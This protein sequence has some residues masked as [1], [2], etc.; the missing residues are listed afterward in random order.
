[1]IG[2]RSAGIRDFLLAALSGL[3]LALPYVDRELFLLGWI[4]F[5]PLLWTLHDKRPAQAYRLGLVCGLVLYGVGAWWIVGFLQRLW[6]PGLPLTVL[7]SVLFWLYS[8]QLIALLMLAFQW[9]R[10]RTGW[11]A[12]LLFPPLVVLFFG[13]FPMLFQAQLGESQS[14]FLVALQGTSVV[15]VSGL[16]AMMALVSVLILRWLTGPRAP[17]HDPV[18]VIA[19]LLPMVWLVWGAVSLGH[20]DER[21]AESPTERVGVVQTNTGLNSA[22]QAP[23]YTASYPRAMALS[24][25]LARAGADLV[26]WPEARDNR[27]FQEPRVAAALR[28]ETARLSTAILLQGMEYVDGA[29]GRAEHNSTVLIDSG[30]REQGR[31]RKI[32][33]VAFGEYLPLLERF[34][35]ARRW[36]R[37]QLGEFFTQVAPGNGPER[38]RADAITVIPLI[39]YEALFPVLV[40]DAARGREARELLVVVSNNVWFGP[41]RQPHQHL[42]ASVLRAVE[43]RRPLLHVINNGPSALILPSGRRLFQSEYGEAGAYWIDAPLSEDATD[44]VYTRSPRLLPWVFGLLLAAAII[45][46][47]WAASWRQPAMPV[48]RS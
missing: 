45:R 25:A 37:G 13:Y 6:S 39:C 19:T 35:S 46:A 48:N 38:F 21:V 15:G 10:L 2:R 8:A 43:N 33:R 29:A 17:W 28:R 40:A 9:L 1:M 12:L 23:G 20:W 41:S 26:V 16:D 36:V 11:S 34:P 7:L 3:L 42:N 22:R 5:V 4:G 31:Y 47:L 30:G 27:Y 24:A 14:A 18:S 44:S 32:R